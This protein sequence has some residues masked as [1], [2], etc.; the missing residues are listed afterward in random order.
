MCAMLQAFPTLAWG[1]PGTQCLVWVPPLLD[2]RQGWACR[3]HLRL[4][5]HLHL[6][7]LHPLPAETPSISSEDQACVISHPTPC[8]YVA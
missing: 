8:P 7:H 4:H 1:T 3:K 5:L 6:P 2:S